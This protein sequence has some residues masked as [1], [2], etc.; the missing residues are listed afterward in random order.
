MKLSDLKKDCYQPYKMAFTTEEKAWLKALSLWKKRKLDLS[1]YLCSGKS[2]KKNHWH[3]T[4]RKRR[5]VPDWIRE[6]M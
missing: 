4:S 1:P 3:L 6:L 2:G 5:I